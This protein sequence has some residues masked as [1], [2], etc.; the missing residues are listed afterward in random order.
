MKYQ[1]T[2]NYKSLTLQC[3]INGGGFQMIG[4]G[5]NFENLISGGPDKRVGVLN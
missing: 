3:L 1:Y 2:H 5:K 4:G